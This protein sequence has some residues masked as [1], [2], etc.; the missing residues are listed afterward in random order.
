VGR[1][2]PAPGAGA[3]VSSG[4]GVGDF[5]AEGF[6]LGDQGAQAALGV[7]PGLVAGELVIGQDAG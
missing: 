4:V 7:E 1:L 6:Q 2:V 3:G 5:L